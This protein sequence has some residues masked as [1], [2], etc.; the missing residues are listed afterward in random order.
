[1]PEPLT[2]DAGRARPVLVA[3]GGLPATGKTTLAQRLCVQLPA[4][5]VRIDTIETAIARAEGRSGGVHVWVHPP[6]YLVGSDVAAD[7]LRHGL[8][9]V[10]EAVS[11]VHVAR[12]AWVRAGQAVGAAVLEVEVVCSDVA[13]HRRRVQGRTS[14]VEGLVKPS[15]Q[16]VM[17]RAYEPW[18]RDRLVVDTAV[19]DVDAACRVVHGAV[20]SLSRD[21]AQQLDRSVA[22]AT[23][24]L[25]TADAGEV[26]TL[27]RAAW[28]REAHANHTLAIP[29]LHET[30]EVVRAGLADPDLITWGH[31]YTGGRLVG[32]VRT[33]VVAP[34]VA[35]LGR[36]GVVPDLAGQGL[37]S[38]LL[39][40]AQARLPSDVHRVQLHTGVAS[41]ANQRFYERHGYL[42]ID[43]AAGPPGTVSYAK[44]LRR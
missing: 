19:L 32:M 1:M 13:E 37:G 28:V 43:D 8:D 41:G 5:Y 33:S 22:A 26:L 20:R 36:L 34:G 31:R 35:L 23:E 25:T 7:Q 15:W 6:G 3:L 4:A 2:S 42:R 27:Q 10:A 14:D 38:A 21:H 17:D 24:R 12:D 29:P 39:A 30:L 40:L 16:Q 18:T 9:V 44:E 11:D